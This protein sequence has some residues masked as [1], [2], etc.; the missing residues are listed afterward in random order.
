MLV[1]PNR[2]CLISKTFSEQLNKSNRMAANSGT[3][4]S[5]RSPLL[6]KRSDSSGH[7][8]SP[9][10]STSTNVQNTSNNRFG[11]SFRRKSPGSSPGT[12]PSISTANL[13]NQTNCCSIIAEFRFPD[14]IIDVFVGNQ[15]THGIGIRDYI[16]SKLS[17]TTEPKTNELIN[18]NHE[19]V[20]HQERYLIELL[21]SN[22]LDNN[23]IQLDEE[24]FIITKYSVYIVESKEKSFG[25]IFHSEILTFLMHEH[26]DDRYQ[27]GDLINRSKLFVDCF[28][29]QQQSYGQHQRSNFYTKTSSSSTDSPSLAIHQQSNT[30]TTMIMIPSQSWQLWL[31]RSALLL[32]KQ[33][34]DDHEQLHC[35]SNDERIRIVSLSN[36]DDDDDPSLKHW[37]QNRLNQIFRLLELSRCPRR[38]VI[39]ALNVYRFWH[40]S[41]IQIRKFFHTRI[42]FELNDDERN[43]LSWQLFESLLAIYQ[44]H[45]DQQK[46]SN[47]K[48]LAIQNLYD[49]FYNY[50]QYYQHQFLLYRLIRLDLYEMGEYLSRLHG[51]YL[52]LVYFILK[53]KCID[54]DDDDQQPPSNH[55]QQIIRLLT[56]KHVT[57]TLILSTE[58]IH[59]HSNS[60][61][62]C[63]VI[64]ECRSIRLIERYLQFLF[65][66]IP[67]LSLRL[68]F[69]LSRI[70]DPS[71]LSV[72]LLINQT[73][74]YCNQ[75]YLCGDDHHDN[76]DELDI[77]HDD[78]ISDDS[79]SSLITNNGKLR[80]SLLPIKR[81][82]V[83]NVHIFLQSLCLKKMITKSPQY[84]WSFKTTVTEF[85]SKHSNIYQQKLN[86]HYGKYRQKLLSQQQNV[87]KTYFDYHII[88]G[89]HCSL[90]FNSNQYC[91]W[92]RFDYTFTN[93]ER[94]EQLFSSSPSSSFDD[95]NN[96]N[97]EYHHHRS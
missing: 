37:I 93:S 27:D 67:R 61:E 9:R 56:S 69:R 23:T 73:L 20:D 38:R 65:N 91:L 51:D 52:H 16:H 92:G 18:G 81:K 33:I 47:E 49:Y 95:P 64:G 80:K 26:E 85:L 46:T 71:R 13:S 59:H 66:Q 44:F 8:R 82:D 79:E 4:G 35:L 14:E 1:F 39:T 84:D 17:T 45:C 88:A 50:R 68:L 83:L 31:Y 7:R 96:N 29:P 63:N 77:H 75:T 41:I 90:L 53:Y 10:R 34:F 70:F 15:C 57:F 22:E 54:N 5:P 89:T 36:Y 72:R 30:S 11:G 94:L 28:S 6:L 25:R 48:S 43:Y 87:M 42:L 55:H 97:V 58:F 24:F 21:S 12:T 2:L 76:D 62:S 32:M 60:N 78:S 3:G 86:D 19:H 74:L 40:R